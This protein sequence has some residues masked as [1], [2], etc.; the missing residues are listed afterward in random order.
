M[1]QAAGGWGFDFGGFG[2]GQA[3]KKVAQVFGWMNAQTPTA[4][5]DGIDHRT[6]LA[7]TCSFSQG[8]TTRINHTPS[9]WLKKKDPRIA[10]TDGCRV[11]IMV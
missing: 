4:A 2:L 11:A 6:A 5:Q 10:M 1:D 7:E 9:L 3:F 8:L